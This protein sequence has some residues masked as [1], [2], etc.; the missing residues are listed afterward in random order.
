MYPEY[1]MELIKPKYSG[2][3]VM[4][5]MYRGERMPTPREQWSLAKSVRRTALTDQNKLVKSEWIYESSDD[6]GEDLGQDVVDEDYEEEL[7]DGE[8]GKDDDE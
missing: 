5:Q 2:D 8:G 3:D 4:W 1:L 6:E 7:E